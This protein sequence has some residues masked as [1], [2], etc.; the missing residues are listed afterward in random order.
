MQCFA[1]L[2]P[3]DRSPVDRSPL[4]LVPTLQ[5]QLI[6]GPL[7]NK[8]YSVR[9]RRGQLCPIHRS[10]SCCGREAF[11][12]ERRQ[13]QLGIRRIDDPQHPRGYRELRSNGEMRKLL[14]RKIVAQNGICGICKEKSTDYGDIVP[15]ADLQNMPTNLYFCGDLSAGRDL[16]VGIIRTATNE[17]NSFRT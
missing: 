11:P 13:R 17:R 7:A 10:A 8:E 5:R 14:D 3:K 2:F 16:D 6:L 4:F 9:L 15:Y 1:R 12:K